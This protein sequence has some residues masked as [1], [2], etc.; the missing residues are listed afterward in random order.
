M[1]QTQKTQVRAETINRLFENAAKCKYGVASVA[2][3]VHDGR[4]VDVT[5]TLTEST[6]ER[7]GNE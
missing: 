4:I 6:R 3:R 1:T 2:L 5:H 7:E